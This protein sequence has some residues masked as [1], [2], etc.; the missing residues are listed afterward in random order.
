MEITAIDICAGAGGWAVAARG[1]P[2]QIIAAYDHWDAACETYRLNHPETEVH[3]VDL[4]ADGVAAELVK[5]H[6][7][8]D[9]ILGGIP[10]QWLSRYR[11]LVKPKPQE[12]DAGR[13]LVDACLA[14]A[15]GIEPRWWCLEDVV[16]LEGEIPLDVPRLILDA[17]FW[18]GQR[19]KRVYVGEFPPPSAWLGT[20]FDRRVLG[21]YLRRGPYRIG[22][23]SINRELVTGN[24]TENPGSALRA[25]PARKAPTVMQHGS[26]RDGEVLVEA[27]ELPTGKRQFEWQELASLQGFPDDYVFFGSPTDVATMIGNAVQIDVG[28][29]ILQAIVNDTRACQPAAREA[30]A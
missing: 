30:H 8:V 9:L 5:R 29:A 21:D 4:A 24:W 25:D 16:Q 11:R 18:C 13:K 3:Q 2:I 14:I 20:S 22:R 28:R 7:D 1:L 12:L 17:K 26:R 6:S 19:R 15:R 10:C 23:Q 27:P